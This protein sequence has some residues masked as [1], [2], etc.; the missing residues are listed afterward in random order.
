MIQPIR[1]M[2]RDRGWQ[3]ETYE[4]EMLF[5]VRT[6]LSRRLRQSGEAVRL[7]LPFGQDWWPYAVR[8]VG[9]SP[10]N[11]RFLFRALL[12]RR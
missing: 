4:F 9:E 11:A 2:A 10:R 3:P 7:Y 6:D 1:E 12:S 8:R 5:G